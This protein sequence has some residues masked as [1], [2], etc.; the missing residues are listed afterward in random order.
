MLTPLLEGL[1]DSAVVNLGGAVTLVV[2]DSPFSLELTTQALMG[3]GM[4][5]RYVCHSAPE[6][7]EIL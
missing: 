4:P 3:F 6:A 5:V 2:D 1:R 7:M